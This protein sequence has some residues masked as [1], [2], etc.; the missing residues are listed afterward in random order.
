MK[1][2]LFIF[3]LACLSVNAFSQKKSLVLPGN[4]H[5][6]VEKL[7]GKIDTNM[8]ISKLSLSELRVLRNAFAA[9]QG[10]LF[11]S[12]ELRSLFG[13]TSWY[14]KLMEAR[15]AKEY[16]AGGGS[17][18]KEIPLKYTPAE[19]K[20]ISRIKAR[21]AELQKLNFKAGAGKKVNTANI[22]N[23][24][25]LETFGGPL[26]EKLGQNGF[27]IVQDSYEQ[28]FQVYENNDYHD[29]PSFVTTDLYLQA[30]HIY[31]D[32]LLRLAEESE[33]NGRLLDFCEAM[34]QLFIKESAENPDAKMREL[35]KWNTAYFAVAVALLIDK[36]ASDVD[37][38]Y[39][40]M[41]ADEIA[42]VKAEQTAFSEFLGY[43][44]VKFAYSLFRPRGHYTRNDLLKRYFRAMMWIQTVPFG[45]DNPDQ[46]LRATQIAEIMEKKGLNGEYNRL[47][48]PI[49][50]LMGE[51]DNVSMLQVQE[52]M[53]SQGVTVKD[54]ST[55]DAK[56]TQLKQAV[57]VLA[58]KQTRIKPK[59]L[60]SSEYKINL[61]PQRYFPDAE[62]LQEMVDVE[63]QVTKRDVSKGLDYFAAM[64]NTPAERILLDELKE[65]QQ[66]SDYVPNLTHMKKRMGE[67]DWNLTI[68]NKWVR[69]LMTM[70]EPDNSYPYFMQGMA[71]DKK[72]LNAALA[73]WAEL[74]HDAI[75][76]GKQPMMAECG[77]GDI[78]EPIVT[79]YVEPN[80]KFWSKA[81]DLIHDTSVAFKR[82]GIENEDIERITTEM[83]E[84][85]EF[86]LNVSK[87]ELKG[88]K[89]TNEENGQIEVVGA[90]FEYLTLEMLNLNNA[91]PL[92]EWSSVEG[93][94]KKIA[95]VAD[96]LTSN[97]DNNPNP[98]ILYEAVG[99]GYE[100][101][102]VVEINGMLYLTRGAVF[103]YREFKRDVND[104]RLTDE[105]W[106]KDL[107]TMPNEGAPVWMNDIVI[108][109]DGVP[110][111]NERIFYSSGC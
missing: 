63:S 14:Y 23:D 61:M 67:I 83:Q 26:R 3:V 69:T 95:L 19:T 6:N 37:P 66:W 24:Y 96:V 99:P 107:E 77:G 55:D 47:V 41:A 10:Y 17:E 35:A 93:A 75:L 46:L 31:F 42:K 18:R 54:L 50:Y 36:P 8:D 25:Q 94:D 15:V 111:D 33:L 48:D 79:G 65:A 62:V 110:Q 92:T 53:K 74:K 44:K 52:L 34:K 70:T 43:T 40:Q 100:I 45:T 85:G 101:Y 86:F 89:L 102:V 71:W 91:E 9:R 2:L 108:P 38:A 104:P 39:A 58:E 7:N 97:G 68:S 51:P 88:E 109:R 20:F 57:E 60:R 76:Y 32:T 13:E 59:F 81:L 4:G 106:Q 82:F 73:S 80:V 27:A 90:N 103:S 105:E 28:L 98:S 78:P 30:F 72:N 21:E 49:T 87:K 22:I 64:G 11:M 12:A 29:F 5:I 1:R 16:E 84:Y 56:Y